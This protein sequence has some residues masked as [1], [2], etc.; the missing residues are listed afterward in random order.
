MSAWA[1]TPPHVSPSGSVPR[2]SGVPLLQN[3]FWSVVPMLVL[4]L[5]LVNVLPAP[6]TRLCCG[7]GSGSSGYP[8]VP[9][10]TSLI[11]FTALAWTTIILF[12]GIGLRSTLR[13]VPGHRPWMY[14]GA[15]ILFTTVHIGSHGSS[16]TRITE[17]RVQS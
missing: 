4:N 10:S 9:R 12:V 11:G 15:A 6:L 14:R 5:A 7:L 13:F 8:R 3:R 17:C 2:R 1:D 16:G